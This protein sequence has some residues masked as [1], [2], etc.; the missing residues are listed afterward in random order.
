[1]F[2]SKVLL[3]DIESTPNLGYTWGRYEQTVIAFKKERELLSFAYKWLGEDKVH[4]VKRK[5]KSDKSLAKKLRNL[6]NEADVVVAHNGDKFD[7][8]ISRARFLVHDISPP[9]PFKTVDT[10][11]VARRH[12]SFNSNSL[13]DLGVSLGVGKKV[14]HQGIDLWLSCMRSD[15]KAWKLMEKYNKKDVILLER[16]Y[17]KLRPWVT[18][19]PDLIAIDGDKRGCPNCASKHVNK[20]GMHCT[21]TTTKQRYKCQDCGAVYLDKLMPSRKVGCRGNL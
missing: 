6:F 14:H 19:H 2:M 3:Y 12:F 15:K 18:N 4:F 8:R 7:Q 13:N 11:K 9:K 21:R 10:L 17:L 16:V 20:H 5:G 1:M